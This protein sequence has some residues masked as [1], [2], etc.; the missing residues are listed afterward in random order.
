MIVR[1]ETPA[2]HAAV[3]R[4][5]QLAFG[6]DNE[7]NLVDALR[8]HAKSIRFSRSDRGRANRWSHLFQSG[9]D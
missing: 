3:R 9:H 4:V 7:A 8:E 6:T 2:D 5:N 1:N